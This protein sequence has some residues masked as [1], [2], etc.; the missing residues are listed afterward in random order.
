MWCMES[1]HDSS[2]STT[3][4][5]LF[6]SKHSQ[7]WRQLRIIR[8]C[9]LLLSRSTWSQLGRGGKCPCCTT[10]ERT[11]LL[12]Q[13]NADRPGSLTPT[14]RSPSTTTILYPPRTPWVQVYDESV[15]C[16]TTESNY[17]DIN[18]YR[19]LASR[20][21]WLCR[22]TCFGTL[23][24]GIDQKGLPMICWACLVKRL[25]EYSP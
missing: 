7:T 17:P 13:S 18:M 14:C 2:T 8:A 20:S 22:L 9:R 25:A 10:P 16:A 5:F 3:A 21:S 1:P 11:G 4:S 6:L 15:V 23:H 24:I 12:Q 19:R